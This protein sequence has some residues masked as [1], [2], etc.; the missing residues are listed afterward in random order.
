MHR[1]SSEKMKNKILFPVCVL[2]FTLCCELSFAQ[3]SASNKSGN[4]GDANY[5]TAIGLRAGYYPGLTIKHFFNGN[6]AFEGIVHFRYHGVGFTGLYEVHVVAFKVPELH[7]YYGIGGHI[8]FYDGH[9]YYKIKHGDYIYYDDRTTSI[10]IDGILGLEY[11][12]PGIPFV[13]GADVKPFFD[14]VEPGPGYWD[15]ALNI[16]FTF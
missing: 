5:N 15:G 10:G 8:G 7:F 16:R 6:K 4:S 14:I 13:V 12:I 9:Y 11:K 1:K 2:V 3:N